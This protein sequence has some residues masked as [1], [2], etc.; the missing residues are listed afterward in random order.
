MRKWEMSI[1]HFESALALCVDNDDD[2]RGSANSVR[3]E[4]T[5]A[6]DRHTESTTGKYDIESLFDKCNESPD[7]KFNLADFTGFDLLVYNLFI[8][9]VIIFLILRT[10][11]DNGNSRKR[12][13]LITS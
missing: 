6:H 8:Y 10:C 11:K 4:L 5:R 2:A 12:W 7:T 1:E 9:C 13:F 3:K